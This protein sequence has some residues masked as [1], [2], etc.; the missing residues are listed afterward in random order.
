[1]VL[2]VTPRVS[3]ILQQILQHFGGEKEIWMRRCDR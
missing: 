3:T 1:M 2:L